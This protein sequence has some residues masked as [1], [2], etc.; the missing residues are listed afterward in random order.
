MRKLFKAIGIPALVGLS[1]I[2]GMGITAVSAEP[3]QG[4]QYGDSW[5]ANNEDC[6]T[7]NR[8]SE[9]AYS[10]LIVNSTGYMRAEYGSDGKIHFE[11][12]NRDF[13]LTSY[14]TM[15]G[16]LDKFG[17]LYASDSFLFVVYGKDNPSG[18]DKQEVIRIVKYDYSWNRLAA[19][20]IIGSNTTIPFDAGS[21][22]MAD[23]GRNLYILTSH[24]MYNGHQSNMFIK[25]SISDMK[26]STV[27]C[28]TSNADTGYVSHSFNQ[29][30]KVIGS[31]VYTLDHGDSYPRS[32]L[33]SVANTHDV[34]TH[35]ESY[36]NLVEYFGN[37]GDN[38]TNANIGGLEANIN[39][40]ATV[41]KSTTQKSSA[42]VQQAYITITPPSNFTRKGTKL[43]WVTDTSDTASMEIGNPQIVDIGGN[44]CLAVIPMYSSSATK[45]RF[46]K[47]DAFGNLSTAKEI[48]EPAGRGASLSDCQIQYD[49]LTRRVVWYTCNENCRINY[50]DLNNNEFV[51]K[52]TFVPICYKFKDMDASKWYSKPGGPIEYVV[53]EGI[54]SGVGSD[55]FSPNGKCTREMMVTILYNADSK[56]A[57]SLKSNPF[58]DVA[59][60]KWYSDPV[61]WAYVNGITSGVGNGIFGVGKSVTRQEM[62][63]LL[64]SYAEYRGFD[65][66]ARKD[67]GK[68]SDAKKVASWAK[69]AMQWA[70][71]NGIINGKSG[72]KLD[73]KGKASRAEVAQ[74]IM[75]FRTKFGE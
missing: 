42:G 49:P 7:Y 38:N 13:E 8:W 12:Y 23:D 59:G 22:R 62:A 43:N 54:M 71:A 44:E 61:Y 69:E 2:C 58:T 15:A 25:M 9:P 51:G 6:N 57:Y 14:G 75:N 5:I 11:N 70:N 40:I 66:S 64:M 56:K 24:Q 55:K 20:S 33:L 65:V 29:Y 39:Y 68:Y 45:L 21:C 46:V 19:C 67:L 30:I 60:G 63:R 32:A 74:M 18:N 17:G 72:N 4:T 48:S 26:S 53:N 34:G 35:S 31:K 50:F 41:G 47:V 36:F 37:V 16:E 28:D 52:Y 27:R 10:N 73:P 1:L 3:R